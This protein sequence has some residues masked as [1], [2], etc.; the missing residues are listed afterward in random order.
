[1]IMLVTCFVNVLQ[2]DIPNSASKY[3]FIFLQI[4]GEQSHKR[5]EY[6]R[7]VTYFQCG[8]QNRKYRK[9]ILTRQILVK[10]YG[11]QN[12]M[13]MHISLNFYRFEMRK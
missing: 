8:H 7:H 11:G 13:S 12:L 6:E 4:F 2:P 10:I 9:Y 3:L 5:F 1:M